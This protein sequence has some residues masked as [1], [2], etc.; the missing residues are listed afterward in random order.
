MSDLRMVRSPV[1]GLH[2]KGDSEE[3]QRLSQLRK[4]SKGAVLE[5]AEGA[6]IPLPFL[7]RRAGIFRPRLYPSFTFVSSM[8]RSFHARE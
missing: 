5:P 3:A 8:L 2:I 7:L 1:R 4:P 6:S